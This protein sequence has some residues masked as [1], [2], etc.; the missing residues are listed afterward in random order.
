VTSLVVRLAG[1]PA[2][3]AI[4]ADAVLPEGRLVAVALPGELDVAP[5]PRALEGLDPAE[6]AALGALPPRRRRTWVG[7]RLA[8]RHA[9]AAEGAA[10]SAA[11]V[12]AIASD[13]RGA[14]QVPRGFRGSIA[15]KD[16]IAVAL[17]KRDDGWTLG[18]DVEA[19]RPLGL[20]LARRILRAEELASLDAIDDAPAR[21]LELL[22]RFAAKEAIY[23]AIDPH[24]RRWVGFLEV[25]LA[26][27]GGAYAVAPSLGAAE[28]RLVVEA[29]AIDA[30]DVVIA[31]ARARLG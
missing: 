21:G 28:P 13:D 22:R 17:A 11:V 12:G 18:V 24:L 26:G 15:H 23:K 2:L 30:G 14:P 27:S 8:L 4:V 6:R 16:E 29:R 25:G 7:G 19:A 31:V 10:E 20:G 9:L 5:P 1:A 3:G